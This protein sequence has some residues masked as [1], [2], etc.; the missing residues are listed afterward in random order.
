[1]KSSAEVTLKAEFIRFSPM[2]YSVAL[3]ILKSKEDAEDV[4]QEVFTH[5]LPRI[6][7]E[8][9]S[10]GAQLPEN[11]GPLLARV[12][13][14]QAIDLYRRRK[15]FVDAEPEDSGID[16]R[17]DNP[18]A[19]VDAME[20]TLAELEPQHREVLTL[21]YLLRLG[22]EEVASRLGLSVQGARKRAEKAKGHLRERMLQS[23]DSDDVNGTGGGV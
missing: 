4:V 21:K 18:F 16:E 10:G 12:A 17:P 20:M 15:H 11:L 5:K 9:E 13:K 23:E 19:R 6:L 8:G 14:N 2:V 1:M 22:W 3:R 7:A